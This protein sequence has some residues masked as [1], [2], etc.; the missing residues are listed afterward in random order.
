MQNRIRLFKPYVPREMIQE[1]SEVLASGQ[2]AQGPRVDEF[3]GNFAKFFML[4]EAVSM[5]SGTA[6]LETAYELAGLKAGDEVITTPLTCAATNLPLIRLGCKLVWADV[7]QSTL[8]IDPLDVHSKITKKTK[9]VVQVHLGGIRAN[10][11]KI[12]IPLISD[13]CQALGIFAGDYTACS[14]QAIKH[15]TSGDGG[16]LICKKEE[17]AHKAKLLRW[18]GIDRSRQVKNDW[19]SYRTRMMCFDIEVPG[20]KRQMNDISAAMALVGLKHYN[21]IFDHRKKIF[22]IYRARLSSLKGV[23]LVDGPEN[24]YWLATL[25]VDR[26][27]DFAKMLF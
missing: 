15:F 19:E 7:L 23:S 6:A 25:L 22:E 16:M 9:A 2:L 20:C 21:E 26:R 1:I 13:A 24:V 17:D 18:F 8:C 11:G 14:F 4:R 10:V 27:D 5:S 3:E 12:H